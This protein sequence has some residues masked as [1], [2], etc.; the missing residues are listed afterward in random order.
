[1][2]GHGQQDA[3][4]GGVDVI[5]MP[6]EA[7]HADTSRVS[8]AVIAALAFDTAAV[9]ADF[10]GTRFCDSAGIAGLLAAARLADAFHITL[11]LVVPPDAVTRV[12]G[13]AG[14][15]QALPVYP[16]LSEALSARPPPWPGPGD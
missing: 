5:V 11:R 12:F 4:P 15:D 8:A 9:V 7:G 6:A 2:D 14:V 3:V 10:T 1:M 16:T 13:L